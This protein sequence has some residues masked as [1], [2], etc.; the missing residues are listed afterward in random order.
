LGRAM[1]DSSESTSKLRRSGRVT[2]S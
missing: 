2:E 1:V